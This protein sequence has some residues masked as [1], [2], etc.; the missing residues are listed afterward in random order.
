[1]IVVI[2][3]GLGNL[4]SIENM[5]CRAGVEVTISR[6]LDMRPCGLNAYS[7]RGRPLSFRNGIA[8]KAWL[9]GCAE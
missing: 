2:D 8:A 6:S 1:M 4:R 3:Y 9:G 7:S 5:L